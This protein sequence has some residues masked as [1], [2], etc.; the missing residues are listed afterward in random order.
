M[1]SSPSCVEYSGRWGWAAMRPSLV[2]PTGRAS[3]GRAGHRPPAAADCIRRG[4]ASLLKPSDPS[5]TPERTD[6]SQ[7]EPLVKLAEQGE[8][9]VLNYNVPEPTAYTGRNLIEL[10]YPKEIFRNLPGTAVQLGPG[11]MSAADLEGFLLERSIVTGSKSLMAARARG[12]ARARRAPG[13]RTRTSTL[14]TAEVGAG[15]LT[16][17]QIGVAYNL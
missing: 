8:A 16:L 17:D 13:P 6:M 5:P 10:V 7:S 9:A 2:H 11:P 14:A 15:D 1:T 4:G 3:P 12:T